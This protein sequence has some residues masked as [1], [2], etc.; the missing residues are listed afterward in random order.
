MSYMYTPP[1]VWKMLNKSNQATNS[2]AMNS[3]TAGPR[4]EAE[5]PR[6]DRPLQLYSLATPNGVKAS[7][8]LEELL[9]AGA[10][11]HYDAHRIHIGKGEQFSSG[12][13]ELNPNSK[14]PALIDY[15]GD[16]PIKLFESGAILLYLAEK[17]GMFLPAGPERYECLAWLFW[18]IGAGPYVGG[19][20]G[21]F[22]VYAPEKQEYPINRFTMEVKRQLDLLDR[23]LAER[24][25]ICGD[26]YTIADIA[27][28]PWY[29]TIVLNETYGAAEFLS[30]ESYEHV[31]RWAKEIAAR[32]AVIKG[33][34]V[35]ASDP[36]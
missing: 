1:K 34:K 20:F 22:Y 18:Q 15:A 3:D 26:D 5:L 8:M 2:A 7:V 11:A 4:Y 6:G 13:C 31:M 19:G 29:G 10:D 30:A 17:Y 33:R 23:R 9:A 16:R 21:H 36:G 25:Y 28:W 24:R 35:P 27:I 32:P 14:I 12:F